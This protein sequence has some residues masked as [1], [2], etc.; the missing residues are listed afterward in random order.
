MEEKMD[1]AYDID[2]F[3]YDFDP[4][5][6]N[7][8]VDDR[9]EHVANIYAWICEHNKG[10]MDWLQNIIDGNPHSEDAAKAMA[11]IVRMNNF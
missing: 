9:E 8:N 3:A 4:Y 5:E 1:L 11:L 6:Y 7:D 2:L 10:L